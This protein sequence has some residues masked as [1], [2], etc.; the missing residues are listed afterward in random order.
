LKNLR[1][2]PAC[3]DTHSAK[4]YCGRPV[5]I[6]ITRIGASNEPLYS[7]SEFGRSDEPIRLSI[8]SIITKEELKANER[9]RER[10]TG[11][12]YRGE[13]YDKDLQEEDEDF[14]QSI[15]DHDSRQQSVLRLLFNK[16]KM[17]WHYSWIANKHTARSNHALYCYI[18]VPHG[19]DAFRCVFV[20]VSPYFQVYSRKR[21]NEAEASLFSAPFMKPESGNFLESVEVDQSGQSQLKYADFMIPPVGGQE[22]AQLGDFDDVGT[23]EIE[24]F[25]KFFLDSFW[26]LDDDAVSH[27]EEFGVKYGTPKRDRVD[28]ARDFES[29]CLEPGFYE[30]SFSD[31]EFTQPIIPG[32]DNEENEVNVKLWR[33]VVILSLVEAHWCEIQHSSQQTKLAE[34]LFSVGELDFEPLGFGEVKRMR[35]KSSVGN[36][37]PEH[38]RTIVKNL[39]TFLIEEHTFTKSIEETMSSF[40]RNSTVKQ[41]RVAFVR[42]THEQIGVFC[43]SNGISLED[44][45]QLFE[46]NPSVL[47]LKQAA[48]RLRMLNE[49]VDSYTDDLKDDT[50]DR[51]EHKRGRSALLGDMADI[52]LYNISGV[53]RMDEQLLDANEFMREMRGLPW[54]LRK[55]IRYIESTFTLEQEGYERVHMQGN[56]KLLSN[57]GNLYITDGKL[58]KFTLSSPVPWSK[59]LAEYYK[60]WFLPEQIACC[61]E[62]YYSDT[63]KMVRMIRYSCNRLHFTLSFQEYDQDYAIW[64]VVFE[65]DGYANLVSQSPGF[66]DTTQNQPPL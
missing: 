24:N 21:P 65:R 25:K 26:T 36:N 22:T 2:F 27:I 33:L 61:L 41:R 44:F 66:F 23:V 34:P 62:H 16:R 45:D 59:R 20:A 47:F 9:T 40:P 60:A 19:E 50:L 52:K 55:M 42:V 4:G 31:R 63:E 53:W 35:R 37:V 7:W 43:S 57:G 12:L 51:I 6:R 18:M 64:K 14:Y 49:L 3:S 38:N 8:G 5:I 1:C 54:V 32:A 58:H 48:V 10:P 11:A 30:S 46:D 28:S 13:V 29:N 39:A 56:K 15:G 17:G